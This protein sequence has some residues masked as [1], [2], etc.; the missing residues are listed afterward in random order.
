[1]SGL[2]NYRN[3]IKKIAIMDLRMRY[4]NSVLGFLWSLLQ[5]MLM[6]LV[7]Y[8]VFTHLFVNTSIEPYPL[9]LL[10]GIISWGFLDKATGFSL[11]SI[12]GK[13]S[14]IKKVYFPR[15]VLVISAC[16]TALM[17][18][19][20]EFAVFAGFMLIYG[21]MPTIVAVLFPLVLLIEFILVLGISFAIASLNVRFRDIQWIWAVI[22]Q[23]GFFATPIMYSI[24]LFQN[25]RYLLLLTYNPMG[26]IIEM[27][28][29]TL[30]YGRWPA[31]TELLFTGVVA[32][33]LLML[34]L[35]LFRHLEPSFAEEV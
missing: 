28:R 1:M 18:T 4:K 24:S 34:G 30:I 25:S 29:N 19:C 20:I 35:V 3:L 5:P 8:I 6:L 23:C 16:L 14:L 11:N 31:I 21:V 2:W 15:E 13:P 27:L 7:L 17:M 12:V 26:I 32:F 9:F 10:L 33:A 22:M